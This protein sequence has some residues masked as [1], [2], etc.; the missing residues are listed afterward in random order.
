MVGVPP[1]NRDYS[2]PMDKWE[3]LRADGQSHHIRRRD[4]CV[5]HPIHFERNVIRMAEGTKTESDERGE[6]EKFVESHV[7]IARDVLT[8]AIGTVVPGVSSEPPESKD[9]N[10]DKEEDKK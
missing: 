2:I 4:H 3:L 9:G 6:P 8:D 10:K 1:P 7:D 5:L